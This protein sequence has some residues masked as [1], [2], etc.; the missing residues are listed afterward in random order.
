MAVSEAQDTLEH[1]CLLN[2]LAEHVWA[3][4]G[5]LLTPCLRLENVR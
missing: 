1:F 2:D 4:H 3:D 5:R